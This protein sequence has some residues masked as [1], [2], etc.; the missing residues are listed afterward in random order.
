MFARVSRCPQVPI[1][2]IPGRFATALLFAPLAA[3]LFQLRVQDA[4]VLAGTCL[5]CHG[6]EGRS[7]GAMQ[8][9]ATPPAACCSACGLRTGQAPDATV[10]TPREGY[11][12][13]Q[14]EA[15]AFGS[16]TGRSLMSCTR[17]TVS[18]ARLAL[19]TSCI[20]RAGAARGGGGR[21]LRLTAALYLRASAPNDILTLIALPA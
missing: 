2:H 8:L 16:P 21:Q 12:D 10:M 13:A 20:T 17:R 6:P 1:P 5:N 19:P 9:A 4:S 7:A 11:D 15:L 14:V 3:S 18:P